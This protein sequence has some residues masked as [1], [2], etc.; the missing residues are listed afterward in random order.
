MLHAPALP[1]TSRL[2]SIRSAL[3]ESISL[4]TDF[5]GTTQLSD[6]LRS[7]IIAVRRCA[8]RC[9]P[10]VLAGRNAGSPGSR[11]ICFHAFLGSPTARDTNVPRQ[12]G[13]LLV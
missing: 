4:F 2:P 9:C 10:S 6:F 5:V 3:T 13:A 7:F 1:L 8:S 11:A 12:S